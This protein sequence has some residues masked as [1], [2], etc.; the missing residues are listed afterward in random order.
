MRSKAEGELGERLPGEGCP[1]VDGVAGILL[2]VVWQAEEKRGRVASLEVARKERV[3]QNWGRE[4]GLGRSVRR[5][6]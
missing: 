2:S 4:G 3:Q 5:R 1:G 6:P